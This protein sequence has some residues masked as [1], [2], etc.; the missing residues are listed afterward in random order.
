[1]CSSEEPPNSDVA[2]SAKLPMFTISKKYAKNCDKTTKTAAEEELLLFC[3]FP[4]STEK[5]LFSQ[6]VR[7][8]DRLLAHPFAT[9]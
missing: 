1:M 7:P 3:N 4:Y 8:D 2:H 5:L 9:A 6:N